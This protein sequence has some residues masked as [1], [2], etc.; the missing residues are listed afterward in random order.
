[1]RD[2]T[3][4]RRWRISHAAPADFA[5]PVFERMRMPSPAAAPETP[6]RGEQ[7][8]VDG[9]RRE[10]VERIRREIA[11]GTYDTDEKWLAAEAEL[12]RRIEERM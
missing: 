8:G 5:A 6:D 2:A 1:M 10:L 4:W 12:L 9:I 11:A 7:P 3:R